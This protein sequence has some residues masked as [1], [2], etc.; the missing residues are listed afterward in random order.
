[1]K[2]DL[3][4]L[5]WHVLQYVMLQNWGLFFHLRVKNGKGRTLH[6]MVDVMSTIEEGCNMKR[7]CMVSYS[8]GRWVIKLAVTKEVQQ[9]LNV[10]LFLWMTMA[11][12]PA[13]NPG[14]GSIQQLR[15]MNNSSHC[16]L[17]DDLRT[18]NHCVIS[19]CGVIVSVSRATMTH[20][21]WRSNYNHLMFSID[22]L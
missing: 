15:F 17:K 4:H 9:Q 13:T 21:L 22:K 8:Q 11:L 10:R 16:L 7:P 3:C 2:T 12:K 5:F 20:L 18:L 19:L 1:M 14:S 6:L